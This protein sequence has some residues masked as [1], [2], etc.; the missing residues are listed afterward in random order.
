MAKRALFVC[1][2]LLSLGLA[3]LHASVPAYA[4]EY[5]Y[6]DEYEQYGE[7]TNTEAD[8][9][10]DSDA[11]SD[12]EKDKEKEEAKKEEPPPKRTFVVYYDANGGEGNMD[13]SVFVEGDPAH[14]TRCSF[15]RAGYTFEGWSTAPDGSG[16][17]VTDGSDITSLLS[18]DSLTLYALWGSQIYLIR[19]AS[20]V[21]AGSLTPASGSMSSQLAVHDAE[22]ALMPCGF[23]RPGYQAMG[24]RDSNGEFHDFESHGV[25]FVENTS[26]TSWKL[27]SVTLAQAR[28]DAEGKWSCQ[29]SVV[30]EGKDGGTYVAVGYIHYDN[31]NMDSYDSEIAI[32]NLESGEVVKH[33]SHLMLEHANDIAYRPDNGH[34][35]VAQGGLNEGYP[36]GIVE[37]DENLN[38][39]RTVTPEGT[40]NIWNI[41]Y[42]E[43]SFY[44]IGNVNGDSFAR[45]NPTGET[46]DLIRLDNNLNVIDQHAIDFSSEGFSGQGMACDGDHL[47]AILVNFAE[48]DAVQKQRLNIFTLDGQPRGNQFIDILAEVESSSWLNGRMY[49]TT[50]GG[51]GCTVYGT[52]LASTTMT[53]IWQANTYDVAFDANGVRGATL[54]AGIQ[55]Q[56]DSE[57]SIPAEEATCPGYEF[58]G[59]NDK[60]DGSGRTFKPG[61]RVINL[62]ESGTITLYAQW[63]RPA[64]PFVADNGS[65]VRSN[66]QSKAK[67]A[68]TATAIGITLITCLRKRQ[69]GL[70]AQSVATS[71]GT[72]AA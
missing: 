17:N 72:S 24:W 27:A 44:A 39:V 50:N 6:E 40:H 13:P 45:G 4:E 16:V 57:F 20:G 28:P 56:Y 37:L 8:S 58:A 67:R 38:E 32:Y 63:E 43:G 66:R 5:S 49:F 34:F 15:T 71:F 7:P 70:A 69:E 42:A 48:H 26:T 10:T 46:S 35:Y 2:L 9:Q 14:A 29:G 68:T 61:D 30:F 36:D 64:T 60:P 1:V 59:W 33:A 22:V 25:N 21:P 31:G 54:P 3:A 18:S 55:T 51:S 53:A 65:N 19:Y 12:E 41:T 52:D 62:V 11:K 47:Y 23:K